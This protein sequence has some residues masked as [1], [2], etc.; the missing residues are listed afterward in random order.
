M[1]MWIGD[2]IWKLCRNGDLVYVDIRVVVTVTVFVW[3]KCVQPLKARR[4]N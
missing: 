2:H 4:I 3:K 1:E